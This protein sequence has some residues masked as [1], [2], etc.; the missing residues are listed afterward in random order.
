MVAAIGRAGPPAGGD[1]LLGAVEGVEAGAQRV[2][3][4]L[5][6]VGGRGDL[7]GRE[8]GAAQAQGHRIAL[9]IGVGGAPEL[10]Q[11]APLTRIRDQ[12]I[13]VRQ[14]GGVAEPAGVVRLEE[15][16]IARE[17]VAAQAGLDVDDVALGG[18]RDA[19]DALGAAGA[20]ALAPE[21]AHADEQHGERP[22]DEDEH[23]RQDGEGGRDEAARKAMGDG[24]SHR[25][26]RSADLCTF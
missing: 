13:H 15:L 3:T 8:V 20:A 11:R 23:Q 17:Q 22:R 6:V 7:G 19:Q 12:Q 26:G 9:D 14:V 21:V 25:S 24:L 16:R 4:A 5:A 2:E 10:A 18:G 1:A